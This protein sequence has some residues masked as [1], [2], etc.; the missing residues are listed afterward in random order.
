MMYDK[1][2]Y[3]QEEAIQDHAAFDVKNVSFDDTGVSFKI[4]VQYQLTDNGVK[5]SIINDSIKE[6]N[7]FPI[8]SRDFLP[9]FSTST[10]L[11]E[12]IYYILYNNIFILHILCAYYY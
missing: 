8:A 6:S 10:L 3:T 4:A 12:K 11:L 1:C 7:E 2:G 5:A 9:Y